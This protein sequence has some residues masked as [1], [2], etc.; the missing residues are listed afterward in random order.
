MTIVGE[1]RPVLVIRRYLAVVAFYQPVYPDIED[2]YLI[3]QSL[4]VCAHPGEV[5]HQLPIVAAEQVLGHQVADLAV[6]KLSRAKH[7]ERV[8][9]CSERCRAARG[10]SHAD[11][12]H[13]QVIL[14][15]ICVE[16]AQ[17]GRDGGFL[18]LVHRRIQV[19][20]HGPDSHVVEFDVC[21]AY[22]GATSIQYW[23]ARPRRPL[24]GDE[25]AFKVQIRSSCPDRFPASRGSSW[26]RCPRS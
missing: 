21:F 3:M 15:V 17:I 25:A 9:S 23:I 7:R 1:Y 22:F 12:V 10:R 26:A 11:A 19:E 8:A 5:G 6:P 16:I 2:V 18:D 24:L 20:R 14:A 4:V 13:A